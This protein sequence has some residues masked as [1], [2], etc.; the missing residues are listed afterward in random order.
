MLV[1]A[2]TFVRP[3]AWSYIPR[4]TEPRV[5][6]D[7]AP[8]IGTS[9]RSQRWQAHGCEGGVASIDR[10]AEAR[11]ELHVCHYRLLRWSLDHEPRLGNT[12]SGSPSRGPSV[13][14]PRW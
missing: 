4:R 8:A 1:S 14:G 3:S 2:A 10:L 9:V 13:F 6:R 5:P 7:E 12:A 11:E